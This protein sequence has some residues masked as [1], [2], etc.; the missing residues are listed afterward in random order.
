[1]AVDNTSD[2]VRPIHGRNGSNSLK[3]TY[4]IVWINLDWCYTLIRTI[5]RDRLT[6][7]LSLVQDRNGSIAIILPNVGSKPN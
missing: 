3:W 7:R 1:M 2:I 5:C 4:F 6:G